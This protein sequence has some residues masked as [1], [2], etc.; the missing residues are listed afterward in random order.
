MTT[1]EG[2]RVYAEERQQSILTQARSQGSVDVEALSSG[3]E[4][5]AETIR[6]DLKTLERAGQVRRVH[7]GAIPTERL[8]FEPA[9][10]QRDHVMTAAKQAIA[11]R[12][13]E[14]VPEEGALLIDAGSTTRR[15]AQVLPDDRALTVVTNSPAIGLSLA[16]RDDITV[17]LL[18][19]RVRKKTLATVDDWAVQAV[20]RV[21]VDVAFVATNG[22]SV[23]RGLTT[24]D[25]AEANI[26]RAMIASARRVVVLADHTKIDEDYFA[27]F[28]D[29]SD[30]DL[31]VTDAGLSDAAKAQLTQAGL[32]V[33][34]ADLPQHPRK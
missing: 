32:A 14:E 21:H 7:G 13:L 24:P 9:L 1:G 2:G 19:G 22:L 10:A 16:H 23:P 20:S 29:L 33:A 30:I 12:A 3:L 27:R 11:E 17:M 25:P 31:L 5:S 18:G 15:F 6:R 8:T 34:R 4:V 26:K 28:G